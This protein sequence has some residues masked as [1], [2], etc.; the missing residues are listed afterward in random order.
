M[1]KTGL[2]IWALSFAELLTVLKN[3]GFGMNGWRQE[4]G[5]EEQNAMDQELKALLDDFTR[6]HEAEDKESALLK[7]RHIMEKLIGNIFVLEGLAEQFD[8]RNTAGKLSGQRRSVRS[9]QPTIE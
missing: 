9:F 2:K 3:E 8:E 7:A 1:K 6:R 5:Q 4:H